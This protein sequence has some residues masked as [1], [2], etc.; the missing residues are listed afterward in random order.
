MPENSIEIFKLN[1]LERFALFWETR[2]LGRRVEDL[3]DLMAVSIFFDR[4]IYPQELQVAED[5]LTILLENE[6][7]VQHV[8]ERIRVRL[9]HYIKHPHDFLIDREKVFELISEDIQLYGVM[10][11]IFE[12][13]GFL[14]SIEEEAEDVIRK[15][16]DRH[17]STKTQEDMRTRSKNWE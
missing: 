1:L 15:Q 14:S 12:A 9:N 3:I 16:Y 8:M 17:W 10:R 7:D 11:D 2:G 6:R 5:K 13:D 4:A